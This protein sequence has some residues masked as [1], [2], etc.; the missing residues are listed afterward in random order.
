MTAPCQPSQIGV[1]QATPISV[2]SGPIE[3][4]DRI[5]PSAQRI[6]IRP[7]PGINVAAASHGDAA[8]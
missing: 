5:T 4:M 1:N 6:P 3:R 2:A 7:N 8:A